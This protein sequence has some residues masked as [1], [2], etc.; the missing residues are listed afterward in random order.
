MFETINSGILA[1][2]ILE[3]VRKLEQMYLVSVKTVLANLLLFTASD[4][5][6]S[7]IDTG[8]F[9]ICIKYFN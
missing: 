6:F 1:K 2:E 4:I 8:T 7:S 3:L 5:T 9:S